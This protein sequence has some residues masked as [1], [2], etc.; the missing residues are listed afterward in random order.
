[1]RIN[2]NGFDPLS[3]SAITDASRMFT[4]WVTHPNFRNV[5]ET[6]L[7]KENIYQTLRFLLN[8]AFHLDEV[9]LTKQKHHI[10]NK[11]ILLDCPLSPS[12]SV[13]GHFRCQI[14][15]STAHQGC[16]GRVKRKVGCCGSGHTK[17]PRTQPK[18]TTERS[19]I[20]TAHS[21]SIA[22]LTSTLKDV[23]SVI[24]NLAGKKRLSTTSQICKPLFQTATR[25]SSWMSRR[26]P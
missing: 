18:L 14:G 7:M 26:Q 9:R 10:H 1:M 12:D 16:P 6:L 22:N 11:C 5:E 15:F 24:H 19:E 20:G 17:P 21:T 2:I 13:A 3:T 8:D 23:Q 25:M 4:Q